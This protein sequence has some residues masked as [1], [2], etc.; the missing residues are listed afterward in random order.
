MIFV[1]FCD[2]FEKLK[3]KVYDKKLFKL[4]DIGQ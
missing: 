3:I 2:D 4:V 1:I